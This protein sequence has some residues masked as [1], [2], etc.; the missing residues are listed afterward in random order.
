MLNVLIALLNLLFKDQYKWVD[1][2]N[3]VKKKQKK[4]RN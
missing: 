3:Q 1:D 2:S 4:I